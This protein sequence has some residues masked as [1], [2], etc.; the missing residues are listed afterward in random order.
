[1]ANQAP[2]GNGCP[3]L[4][5]DL[6]RDVVYEVPGVGWISSSPVVFGSL[7]VLSCGDGAG[8]R[9]IGFSLERGE[10]AWE[11]QT[12]PPTPSTSRPRVRRRGRWTRP[13]SPTASM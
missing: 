9:L 2:G 13:R 1:M 11:A 12:P 3:G 6:E 7:A 10:V 8:E 4:L 5:F